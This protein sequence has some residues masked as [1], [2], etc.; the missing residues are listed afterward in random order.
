MREF[1]G[2]GEDEQFV[3]HVLRHTFVSRLV[4]RGVSLKVCS[5]LA[6]HRTIITTMRYAKL[7]P[8]NL[9]DAINL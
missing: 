5:E 7:A 2:Y 9:T 4:Q 1:L 3:F 6:G 8:R